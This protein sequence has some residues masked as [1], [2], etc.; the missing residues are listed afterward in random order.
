MRID[1]FKERDILKKI[2]PYRESKEAVI[3]TGMRRTGKT[4]LLRY[5]YKETESENK[6]LL[7]LENPLNR[8]YFEEENFDKI[9]A[10]LGILGINFSE[11][12][13]VFLDEIQLFKNIPKIVKYF[14]DHF[15][16]KFFLTGSTNYYSRKMFEESLAGRKIVF[17]LFPLTFKE[18][19]AFT[20][21]GINLPSQ[22]NNVS[23]PIF[24]KLSTL[25][26][27]Y[28]MF[29]GFPEV[30]LKQSVAEKNAALDDI[31]RSYFNLEVIQMSN[32]RKSSVI[33][34]LMLLLM[35]RAGERIDVQNISQ[36]LGISRAT[37]YSYLE[38]LEGSY[39]IKLLKPYN[40]GSKMEIRKSN[41]IYVCDVGLVRHF[42]HAAEDCLFENSVFQNLRIRGDIKY[43]ERKSG[44]HICFI[45]K[46]NNKIVA[47]DTALHPRK[48]DLTRLSR[49]A[50][51][52][53][54]DEFSIISKYFSDL[55]KT[56]YGFMV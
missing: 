16:T 47:Y 50:G 2:E 42:A 37:T 17:E 32:Y 24:E 21:R 19:V 10:S 56:I 11:P 31:F 18:F 9:Q 33:R 29:G 3:I 54:M 48:T 28:I 7:D 52:I 23:R 30:V 26:D 51:E 39:F 34:D 49:I 35:N 41:K 25:Y 44:T 27:E 46:E 6:L 15:Q 36:E 14:I 43:Y 38:F 4:T 8:K 5:L 12:S 55:D 45:S 20:D 53:K 22:K 40:L 13:Y 1:R